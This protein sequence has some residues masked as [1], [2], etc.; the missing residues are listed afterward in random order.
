MEIFTQGHQALLTDLYELTMA[1][2]YFQNHVNYP[3][4]FE[5]FVRTLPPRRS[6]LIAAGLEQG[7]DFLERLQFHEEDIE[8]LRSH[9]IFA[10]VNKKFFDYLRKFRFTGELWAMTEGTLV[11]S[12]EP[13]LRVTAPLIEAQIV[14]TYLLSMINYQTL[15]ATKAARVITA[16]EG[17]AV[18][19]F[20]TRRAHGPE[21]GV[22]AARAAYLGG[23]I[24]SSNV[25]AGFKLGIP[26]YGTA[27]HSWTMTFETEEEAFKKYFDVFPDSTTLLIDTYDTLEGAKKAAR[28]G[29][30][31][32]GIRIDSGDLLETS[33]RVRQILDEAGLQEVQIVAS[34]D[35][36]EYSI[37]ELVRHGAPID[38]FG[39][40]TELA[41]SRDAPALGGVYKLVEQIID[42]RTRY[43][44]KLSFHKAT[45]PGKKQVFRITDG[46]GKFDHD[47]IAQDAE[48]P[49]GT[50]LLHCVMREGKRV[51]PLP[52]LPTLRQQAASNL[53]RLDERYK[54]LDSTA[55]YPVEKSPALEELFQKIKRMKPQDAAEDTSAESYLSLALC[56]TDYSK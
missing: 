13:I 53:A 24:G 34:S 56:Q 51:E 33:K 23:C 37:R 55:Q 52:G 43:R 48:K 4:T 10:H 21:A 30:K 44:A 38:I 12:D 40:G 31:L 25:Y 49:E 46:R 9:P 19:E 14:E 27:A 42:G 6:Y 2:A 22:L 26:I 5:L 54:W 3:S 28:I 18:I 47:L 36:N 41:T 39:V 11:F 15:I 50:P 8:F 32:K 29:K 1:S 20:G 35:L 7:V 16:A 45:Y 17:R